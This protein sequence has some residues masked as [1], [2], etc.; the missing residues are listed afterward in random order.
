MGSLWG[1][2]LLFVLML[3]IIYVNVYLYFCANQTELK[4]SVKTRNRR[5]V[6]S[7]SE[8]SDASYDVEN[9]LPTSDYV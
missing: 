8:N 2:Y 1:F 7:L 6:T 5:R 3:I 9:R 4:V